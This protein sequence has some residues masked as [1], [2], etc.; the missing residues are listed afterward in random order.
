MGLPV[1]NQAIWTPNPVQGLT[2]DPGELTPVL[3]W[4]QTA[5]PSLT[6]GGAGGTSQGFAV[7]GTNWRRKKALA[8]PGEGEWHSNRDT[9]QLF[10]TLTCYPTH[11]KKLA[12]RGDCKILQRC[13]VSPSPQ[14]YRCLCIGGGNTP[15]GVSPHPQGARLA[16]RLVR[17]GDGIHYPVGQPLLG[18]SLPFL[19]T[20]VADKELLRASK[21]PGAVHVYVQRS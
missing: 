6:D 17:Q 21:A 15:C 12:Q 18:D 4:R 14:L 16:L 2:G 19:L 1:G 3:A 10:P 5:P 7:L 11:G 13:S 20:S 8:S 9:G